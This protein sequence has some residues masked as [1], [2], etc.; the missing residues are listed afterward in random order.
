MFFSQVWSKG[1]KSTD[2][3]LS[4]SMTVELRH[5][6][7]FF[8]VVGVTGIATRVGINTYCFPCS[9]VNQEPVNNFIA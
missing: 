6:Q 5:H 2:I 8:S 3:D 9:Q 4:I 7:S 1:A